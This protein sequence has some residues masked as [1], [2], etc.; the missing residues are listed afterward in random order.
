MYRQGETD[1]YITTA[2]GVIDLDSRVFA[3][4]IIRRSSFSF[5]YRRFYMKFD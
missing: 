5:T 1:S 2:D 4:Y 3:E